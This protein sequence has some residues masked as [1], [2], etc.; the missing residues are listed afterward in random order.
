MASYALDEF[1]GAG[2]LKDMGVKFAEDGWD[3]VPTLKVIGAQDMET[4]ALTDAER[5]SVESP[6]S[7]FVFVLRYTIIIL[8]FQNC[9]TRSKLA[10]PQN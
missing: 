8:L 6:I 1:L 4:L 7:C 5:V 2:I 10:L 9:P 3:D